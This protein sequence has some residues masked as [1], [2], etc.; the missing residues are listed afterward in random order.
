MG[1]GSPCI[2]GNPNGVAIRPHD[3]QEFGY[4]RR[5]ILKTPLAVA[6][7]T[8]ALSQLGKPFDNSAL[9]DF[10]SS[11]FPGYR[12]W[13]DKGAWFCAELA[14]WAV[15]SAGYY[16][17]YLPWPKNRVSPTDQLLIHVNDPN[18]INR[19]TFWDPIPEL[20]LAKWES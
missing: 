14:V 18:W 3:Y 10:L 7:Y 15:E 11:Q 5:M 9:K 2:Q 16:G 13:R 19:D 20:T 12:D 4:R 6:I 1:D 8:S 17:E